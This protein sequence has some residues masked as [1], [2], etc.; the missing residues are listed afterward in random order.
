MKEYKKPNFEHLDGGGG[1]KFPKADFNM[2]IEI[3]DYITKRH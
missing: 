2:E 1:G 3:A